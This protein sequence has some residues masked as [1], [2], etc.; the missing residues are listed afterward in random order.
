MMLEAVMIVLEGDET[1]ANK[2]AASHSTIV[3]PQQHVLIPEGAFRVQSRQIDL[4][5]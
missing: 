1:G 4:R 5:L 2:D 3:A